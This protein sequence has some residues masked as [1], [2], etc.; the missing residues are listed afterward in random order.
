[1]V[2]TRNSCIKVLLGNYSGLLREHVERI[3]P[4]KIWP[5]Y[6]RPFSI[7]ISS[8]CEVLS[9]IRDLSVLLVRVW[10]CQ[11]DLRSLQYNLY[12]Y[13]YYIMNN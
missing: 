7:K 2:A 12:G 4:I 11:I 10:G 6:S 5:V 1:M 9:C 8:D 3:F 13:D